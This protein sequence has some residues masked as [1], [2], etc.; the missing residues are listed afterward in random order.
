[1]YAHGIHQQRVKRQKI[2]MLKNEWSIY[3]SIKFA[4]CTG[5]AIRAVQLFG[6]AGAIVVAALLALVNAQ[7]VFA[8]NGVISGTVTDTS[9]NP[10][11][12]ITVELSKEQVDPF[13]GTFWSFVTSTTT[14]A[15]GSYTFSGLDTGKYRICFANSSIPSL[16]R[17]ECYDDATELDFATD[18][19]LAANATVTSIDAQLAKFGTI[20][21]QVTI[22]G[23]APLANAQI[24]V[25]VFASCCN[26]WSQIGAYNADSNGHYTIAGLEPDSYRLNF[27]DSTYPPTYQQEY[28][29]DTADVDSATDIPVGNEEDVTG[30]DAELAKLGTISGRVTDANSNPIPN[31]RVELNQYDSFFGFWNALYSVYTDS[32]GDYTIIGVSAGTVRLG[33]FDENIPAF[34]ANE[35]YNDADSVETAGDIA[36]ALGE[37]VTGI[38]VQLTKLGSIAGR[39]TDK[40]GN[41][42][43]NFAVALYENDN[44]I[45]NGT[46]D[47][48]GEYI[49]AGLQ[50]GSYNI[51]FGVNYFFPG[52]SIYQPEFY[53]DASTLAAATAIPVGEGEEITGIDAQ[54]ANLGS[55]SGRVTDEA[56]NPLSFIHVLV[57]AA[58]DVGCCNPATIQTDNNGQYTVTGLPTASYRVQ[59]DDSFSGVYESEYYSNAYT[60]EAAT[61]VNVGPSENVTGIDA[62]LAKFATLAGKVT[63]EAGNPLANIHVN[64]YQENTDP[65]CIGSWYSLNGT[66]TD[67]NGAYVF[68]RLSAG[69]YRLHFSE[70]SSPP[71]Y[72]HEFYDN[73]LSLETATDII[74]TLSQVLVLDDV[75][76]AKPSSI[77]GHITDPDGNPIS[78]WCAY[79]R[80][81]NTSTGEWELIEYDCQWDTDDH[82]YRINYVPVGTFRIEF[83][84]MNSLDDN[85]Y[86]REFY[87][88][89][90]TIEEADDIVVT[91][92]Q[93]IENIDA[94]LDKR[95]H[96]SGRVTDGANKALEN[97]SVGVYKRGADTLDGGQTWELVTSDT[98]NGN[99]DYIIFD[100]PPG[101][102]R[103]GFSNGNAL[104]KTEYFTN[105]YYVQNGQDVVVTEGGVVDNVDAQLEG[106]TLNVP[107]LAMQDSM[108]VKE[109][110]TV[111]KLMTNAASVLANDQD[112]ENGALS[113]ILVTPPAHGALTLNADGTFSYVHD[114]SETTSDVFSYRANDGLNESPVISV[115]ITIQSVNDAPVAASDAMTVTQGGTTT[116]LT[117]GVSVLSNDSDV[118]GDSLT[119]VLVDK[120]QHGTLT[121]NANGT[122]SYVHDGS[123]STSDSFTYKASDGQAQ[124]PTTAVSITV[125]NSGEPQPEEHFSFLPL[126][127]R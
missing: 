79:L 32:N 5:R 20:S 42:V 64:L 75:Q 91:S 116:K 34:Y 90:F 53:D 114:G 97:I 68:G 86:R 78:E 106:I 76:L 123:E 37:D 21:G 112:A 104:Y 23:G 127:Y 124:S 16:H 125:T 19:D 61:L 85:T 30:I 7:P 100:L 43:E 38:D 73:A 63:D 36:V 122:F 89:A 45:N 102:Y 58:S 39:V 117:S 110:G 10:I 29:V 96:I 13:L 40:D 69:K 118:E 50:A 6:F 25:Y 81:F 31:V 93:T 84:R 98:T 26:Y 88:N 87:N 109:G 14:V 12:N 121:L 15:N 9:N 77:S 33:F 92:G 56:G 57:Y 99:G 60:F 44:Y 108:T 27:A 3:G 2:F 120:P 107:P 8:Q 119:A 41:P 24:S 22:A 51:G 48:N 65:C 67:A 54:L 46:T 95:T 83:A 11:E 113:A 105:E 115:T 72:Q 49:F 70:F 28:Y 103:V 126:S 62:Q 55:I 18:I 101:S 1:M 80:H 82:T 47:G 111:G 35:Y 17:H 52:S 66:D 59:F 4:S 94:L 74:L 71:L